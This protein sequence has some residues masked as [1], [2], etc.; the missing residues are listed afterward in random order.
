MNPE[1]PWHVPSDQNGDRQPASQTGRNQPNSHL[2]IGEHDDPRHLLEMESN[3]DLEKAVFGW[4]FDNEPSDLGNKVATQAGTVNNESN[5]QLR[6]LSPA[7]LTPASS[8][9]SFESTGSNQSSVSVGSMGSDTS[10]AHSATS[11]PIPFSASDEK[12]DESEKI[13][14]LQEKVAL[15]E[16]QLAKKSTLIVALESSKMDLE[17]TLD[18]ANAFNMEWVKHNKKQLADIAALRLENQRLK[19]SNDSFMRIMPP[20]GQTITITTPPLQ[21]GAPFVAQ[22]NE[23]ERAVSQQRVVQAAPASCQ[24]NVVRILS[25]GS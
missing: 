1:Q 25:P 11:S 12:Q 23:R 3:E 21:Y 20:P 4:V 10:S 2:A 7:K 13:R 22:V 24:P 6:S 9:A 18:K 19:R 15:L 14:Q 5:A 17:N 8:T 16:K